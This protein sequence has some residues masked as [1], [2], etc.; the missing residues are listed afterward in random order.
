MKNSST[1]ASKLWAFFLMLWYL[2]LL[3][4]LLLHTAYKDHAL[5][6]IDLHWLQLFINLQTMRTRLTCE[7]AEGLALKHTKEL[8]RSNVAT[9]TV[10][11]DSTSDL[12][13][14]TMH[15]GKNYQSTKDVEGRWPELSR[16]VLILAR[17]YHSYVKEEFD[18]RRV[19]MK[20]NIN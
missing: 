18:F 1:Q 15:K 7:V 4:I 8:S 12:C 16:V 20:V 6:F 17:Y 13:L 10:T 19:L 2:V 9:F 3:S 11:F 5:A 14:L